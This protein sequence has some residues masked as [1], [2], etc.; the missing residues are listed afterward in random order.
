MEINNRKARYNY[1]IEETV[2]AG[3]EL[4]GTEVKS[5]RAGKA[6]I[7]DS[8][9]IINK[10]EIKIINMFISPYTEGN[11]FNHE[12]TRTR[13]L[14]LHKKEIIKLRIKK[15]TEGYSIIPLKVY[16][17]NKNKAK[18][19]LGIGKGKKE[20]DKRETMKKRD[21]EREIRKKYK[22]FLF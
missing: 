7:N 18:V 20:Y 15:E 13:K 11:Q 5:I 4:K 12:E 8:Y 16:F 1:A 2:E 22:W 19:L 17:N 3:I 6:Q 21:Q 10:N 9:A 14:L